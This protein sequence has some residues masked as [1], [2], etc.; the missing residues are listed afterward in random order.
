MSGELPRFYCDA[1][2]ADEP[3]WQDQERRIQGA[4]GQPCCTLSGLTTGLANLRGDFA[5]VIHGEDE[6]V[7]SFRQIGVATHRFFATGLDDRHFIKGNT[8]ERLKRCLRLVAADMHP[9]AIL[10]LGTC[11]IEVIGDTF[12]RAVEEV[13]SEFDDIP[14]V[15]LHTSGLKLGSQAAMLDWLFST[16]AAL[17]QRAPT[18][19]L[20]RRRKG[21]D[22]APG[23]SARCLNMIG[24]PA[25]SPPGPEW[26][27]VLDTLELEVV[28]SYPRGASLNDWRALRFAPSTFVID[29]SLFPNLLGFL[30]SADRRVVSVPL[31][32]GLVDTERFYRL[33]AETYG[34]SEQLDE[35]IA[36]MKAAATQRIEAFRDRYEGLRMAMGLRMLNNY[37]ADQIAFQGLA[38]YQC[39]RDYGF[40]ITFLVQ[41]PVEKADTY[42]ELLQKAGFDIAFE[43]F[44]EPWTISR[45][46]DGGRY[47]IAYLADHCRAEAT[48]ANVPMIQSGSLAPWFRGTEQNLHRLERILS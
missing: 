23:D 8:N 1:R 17:P 30:E 20:S 41:G 6:C 10:V 7:S 43:M 12:E 42:G 39:L 2:D 46:I 38:D 26:L 36:P 33:I 35:I 18:T 27:E 31:P 40:D 37:H 9:E 25:D 28:G 3:F 19:S 22:E 24:L 5:V 45:Y 44:P 4:T 11:P 16:L 15:A 14:M 13:Q 34:V 32:M 47:D 48:R 29:R 21:S